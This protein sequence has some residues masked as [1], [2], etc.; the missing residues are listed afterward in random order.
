MKSIP[1]VSVI[2]PIYNVSSY[3]EETLSTLS[4]QTFTEFEVICVDDGSTD[5]SLDI[6][7]AYEQKDSRVQW[8]INTV[9]GPGAGEARNLGLSKA[10]GTFV[11][12]LDSDDKFHPE[13]LEKLYKKAVETS[14]DAVLF[15]AIWFDSKTGK[16]M[17]DN[18]T[19]RRELLP[20]QEVFSGKEIP[21]RL[22]QITHG[23]AWKQFYARSF[24]EKYSFRFQPVHV[25]DDVFFTYTTLAVAEKIAVVNEK[26]LYYRVNNGNS[27]ICNKDRD[28]LAPIKVGCLLKQWLETQ[29]LFSLY[30]KTYAQCVLMLVQLYVHSMETQSSR[31]NFDLLYH[32]LQEYG[33]QDLGLLEEGHLH[34]AMG[35]EWIHGILHQT[36]EE[37]FQ[38]KET[39]NLSLF[40]EKKHCVLY[41]FG[42]R[43]DL[44]YDKISG[45]RSW[46]AF[47]LGIVD[48]SESKHGQVYQGVVVSSPDVLKHLRPDVIFVTTPFYF[49]EIKASLISYGFEEEEI[50]LI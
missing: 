15:D 6:L 22:F 12:V 48:G 42:S 13:M 1:K 50:R 31:E 24:L 4:A 5:D 29:G 38:T 8:F 34:K 16:D 11:L 36:V 7:K 10:T 21:D 37:Y 44:V 39:K 26:L 49:E 41:G 3:L 17:G 20:S 35:T 40:Q 46:E 19:L 23:A 32:A 25:I 2:I 27:Q 47:V 28:P 18:T 14:A 9:E 45:Y 33:L 43:M 30:R